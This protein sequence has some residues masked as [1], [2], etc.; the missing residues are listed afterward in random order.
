MVKECVLSYKN[1]NGITT[2]TIPKV[3]SKI[4]FDPIP[5]ALTDFGMFRV[6]PRYA[7]CS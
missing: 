2:T 3:K 5:D 4:R 6:L 1:G 7:C